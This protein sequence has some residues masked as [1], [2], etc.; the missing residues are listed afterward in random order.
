MVGRK[1]SLLH[2]VDGCAFLPAAEEYKDAQYARLNFDSSEG[3]RHEA[4]IQASRLGLKAT[5]KLSLM[6]MV[7]VSVQISHPRFVMTS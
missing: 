4:K 3:V 6:F 1:S 5:A 7:L 2:H